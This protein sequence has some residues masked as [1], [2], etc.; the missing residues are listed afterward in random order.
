MKRKGPK[1]RILKGYT[2]SI[3]GDCIYLAKY[4]H[5]ECW[6]NEAMEHLEVPAHTN[7]IVYAQ[8]KRDARKVGRHF[9]KVYEVTER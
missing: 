6:F 9:G 1:R 2:V 8:N 4:Y 7:I 3:I 5:Y